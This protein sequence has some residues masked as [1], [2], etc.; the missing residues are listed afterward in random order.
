MSWNTDNTDIDLWVTD[1]AGEKCYYANQ[2]NRAGGEL[3]D[4]ITRGFGPERF[5]DVEGNPGEY[6]VQAHYYGNNGNRLSAA[7]HIRLSVI[8]HAGTDEETVEVH[9]A[10]LEQPGDVATLARIQF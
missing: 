10:V 7:T 4:D 8:K 9:T 2:N 5:Q 6:L 3:L 1:P